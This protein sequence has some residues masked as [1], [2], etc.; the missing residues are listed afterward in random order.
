MDLDR[1]ADGGTLHGLCVAE[2][3][4]AMPVR[5]YVFVQDE[6]DR[7]RLLVVPY[8]DFDEGCMQR[9]L[10]KMA[11]WT[12]GRLQIEGVTLPQL[13]LELVDPAGN[14]KRIQCLNLWWRRQE[15]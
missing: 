15:K 5:E 8:P 14:G 2:A 11:E 4:R 12:R 7:A 3:L 9:A 10:G 1:F 6:I 13:P